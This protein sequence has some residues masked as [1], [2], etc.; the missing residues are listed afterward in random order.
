MTS[1]IENLLLNE[2]LVSCRD[3]LPLMLEFITN[4]SFWVGT[5]TDEQHKSFHWR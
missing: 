3:T 4:T 2:N 5:S 1:F